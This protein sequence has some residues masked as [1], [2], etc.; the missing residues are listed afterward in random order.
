M[1][2]QGFTV[3]KGEQKY[4]IHCIL[5]YRLETILRPRLLRGI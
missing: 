1:S 3:G 5:Y 2:P 4:F